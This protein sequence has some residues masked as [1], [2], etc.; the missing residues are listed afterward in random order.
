MF[1]PKQPHGEVSGTGVAGARIYQAGQYYDVDHRYVF[2]DPGVAAP[3]GEER[4]SME[5][6]EAEYQD[7]IRRRERGEKVD[8]PKRKA[9]AE[10]QR[11]IPPIPQ[12][13]PAGTELTPEQQLMQLNVPQ[14]QQLQLETLKALNAALP[15]AERKDEKELKAKL[16]R[17]AGAKNQL[18]KW[19]LENTDAK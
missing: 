5:E 6:A 11:P 4:K 18:V 13:P 8:E 14:L 10:P 12:Q 9:A 3:P 16:I 15:E 2:S 7:R 1:N 19:L 17:G